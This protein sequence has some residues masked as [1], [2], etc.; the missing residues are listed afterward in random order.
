LRDIGIRIGDLPTGA[1]NAITDVPGVTVGHAT[2]V[3]DEPS[4]AR[5]GVT[6]IVPRDG[7]IWSDYVFA[8]WHNFSGNG[9]MTGL[10]WIEET[11]LLGSP[12]G[13]TNTHQVGLVRDFLVRA[14]VESGVDQ[15]FHLPVVGETWDGW[16]SDI[17]SFPLTEADA[18]SAFESASG[19][20]VAEGCVGGGTG[21]ICH[22]FK[23]GIGTSSRV[24]EG[25]TV[26]VLVQA[27]YGRRA[28]LRIDGVAVGRQIGLAEVP[29]P[30][31]EPP[32]G[33]S[34]I[35]I[36][37]TDAPLLPVQCNRV[38]KRIAVGL[39]RVGGYGHDSSGDI[40]LMFAT[41]NRLPAR[42]EPWS[43]ETLPNKAMDGLFHGVADATEEAILNALCA[44]ETTT[45]QKGRTAHAIPLDRVREVVGN[46]P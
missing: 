8:A 4:V 41:G 12:I 22:E 6:M 42:S 11:G 35:V 23:G 7:E 33:G 27:N 31:D 36:A 17:D 38:A 16:L 30:W 20:P 19:G 46:R 25:H 43:L 44:A 45:G 2:V 32:S 34:I 14:G 18:R 10:P 40:F 24:V 9:E 37:A 21:M 28:D 13:I 39:G 1:H 15:A 29:S 26:G 5:T 3:H